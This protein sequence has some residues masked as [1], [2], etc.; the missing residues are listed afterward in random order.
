[1]SDG[2]LGEQF[3]GLGHVFQRFKF[4]T[5]PNPTLSRVDRQYKDRVSTLLGLNAAR[6]THIVNESLEEWN[7]AVD[8]GNDEPDEFYLRE[9]IRRLGVAI[10]EENEAI[11]QAFAA[12]LVDISQN[13]PQGYISRRGR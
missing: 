7:L 1:M 2:G 12:S 10:E 8:M 5:Q 4:P 13:E 3:E 6:L 11:S 9:F